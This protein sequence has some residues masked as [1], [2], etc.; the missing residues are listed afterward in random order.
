MNLREPIQR[1]R[2][3]IDRVVRDRHRAVAALVGDFEI[4]VAIQLLGGLHGVEQLLAVALAP[5]AAFV[6]PELRFHQRAMIVDQ[7]RN[8]VVVAALFVRGEREDD[9]ALW[10]SGLPGGSGSNWRRRSPPSPCRRRCRVRS[11]SRRARCSLNGSRSGDQSS[12]C[13]STTS[14]CATSRTGFCVPSPRS[15]ATRLPFFA[16]PGRHQ[17]AHVFLR[18][19]CRDQPRCHRPRRLRVV[20]DGIARVDLDQLFVNVEKSALLLR[21]LG[22]HALVPMTAHGDRRI[23]VSRRM[24]HGIGALSGLMIFLV[25]GLTLLIGECSQNLRLARSAS[26]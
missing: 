22:M 21:Q 5:A 19:S 14:R 3:P 18:E 2:Q 12:L 4:E 25:V 9:V 7:P 6:Q 20:P 11:S 13:A 10:A 15:R 16:L 1:G 8:A 24:N 17:H 26:I 23:V